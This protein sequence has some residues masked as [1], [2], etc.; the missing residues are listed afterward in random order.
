MSRKNNRRGFTLIELAIV[1]V[2]IG[3]IVAGV[4]AGQSL[5]KQAKLRSVIN[6]VEM[7]RSAYTTFR[8][9]YDAI[10]G[11]FDQAASFFDGAL[12]GD[13]NK[14]IDTS[15]DIGTNTEGLQFFYHLQQS[16]ILPGNLTGVLGTSIE[17][18]KNV[19]QSAYDAR[20]VYWIYGQN[21][22]SR[23]PSGN[24][25]V[26]SGPL[27]NGYNDPTVSVGDAYN[28]DLK[29]DDGK[30]YT[31]KLISYSAVSGECVLSGRRLED[32]NADADGIIGGTRVKDQVYLLTDE[33]D[34]CTV[35]FAF[36]DYSFRPVR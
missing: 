5:V 3:L 15:S 13:G 16:E 9:K 31:G 17:V 4:V 10:A 18:N 12:D 23:F 32:F 14:N 11:D 30:T 20:S 28:M 7:Y 6:E 34:K 2:I 22:W 35:H 33:T 25:L 1:I 21:L 36:D 29:I 26:L 24:S 19:P 27:A 8:L